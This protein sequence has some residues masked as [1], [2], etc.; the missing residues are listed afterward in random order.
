MLQRRVVITGIGLVTPL[1]TGHGHK[2]FEHL[3]AGRCGI[4]PIPASLKLPESCNV[5]Q[6]GSVPRGTSEDEYNDAAF[7]NQK[8]TS[9]FIR[10]AM[11]A[12]DIALRHANLESPTQLYE[13]HRCGVA[14]GNGGIG[15]ITEIVATQRQLDQSYKKV[16]PY[17]VPKILVNM[18]SG[19]VSM[20]YGLKGPVH[21]AATACAAALHSIGDAYNFIRLDMADCIVAGG[22]DASIDELSLVGFNR[23]KALSNPTP[24]SDPQ[25]YPSSRPFD[26]NRNGFVMGE[27]AGILVLEERDAAIRRG[28]TIIAEV[29]GYGLSGDAYHSTSP[30]PDGIGAMQSMANALRDARLEIS[31]IDYVNCHATSTPI[32]DAIEAKAVATLLDKSSAKK[33]RP[34]YVSS[35][36]GHTGHLLG[37]A[38]SVELAFAALALQTGVLPATLNLKDIDP[39]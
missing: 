31:D 21:S 35:T 1:G 4:K 23:M 33:S 19:H 18:A 34:I 38:G 17:F 11:T 27:G 29:C 5:T 28:A 2:I 14:I 8:E 3:V 6:C 7:K 37:A 16:S 39:A 13:A 30:H 9:L 12:A 26:I 20:K 25:T 15:S 36:K 24:Q 10:Y 22:T 32:G